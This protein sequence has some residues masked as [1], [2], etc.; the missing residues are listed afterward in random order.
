M[1]KSSKIL[2]VIFAAVL[3][4]GAL[5]LAVFASDK[6]NVQG[7]F[8][9]AGVGYETW[10]EAVLAAENTYTIYLNEDWTVGNTITISGESTKVR[11]NLN[12]KTVTAGS[13]LSVTGQGVKD[14]D[15]RPI[16]KV[17]NAA[18]FVLE[19]DGTF[20]LKS[21]VVE[22]IGA[23][24]VTVNAGGANGGIVVNHATVNY[25]WHTAYT[26]FRIHDR[27]VLNVSGCITANAEDAK[28]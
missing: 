24:T 4:V 14:T 21:V 18:N 17:T 3:L 11:L 2:I 7:K 27:A 15:V 9:V 12:G 23:S 1:K 8:V 20:Y 5:A 26:T 19:G 6:D 13:A 10:E 28:R 16:F 22:A 25:A